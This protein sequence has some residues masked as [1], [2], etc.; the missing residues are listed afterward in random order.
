VNQIVIDLDTAAGFHPPKIVI[1]EN[2]KTLLDMPGD[3]LAGWIRLV[4]RRLEE[5]NEGDVPSPDGSQPSD[6]PPGTGG[7]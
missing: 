5:N 3:E 6:G 7:R 1:R 4:R 2:G